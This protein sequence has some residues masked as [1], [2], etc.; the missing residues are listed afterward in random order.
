VFE[1]RVM[2]FNI[3]YGSDDDGENSWSKRRTLVFEVIRRHRLDV[4]GLQEALAW[5]LDEIGQALPQYAAVG[6]GRDDGKRAGEFAAILY[7]A[8]RFEVAEQGTF[9][10]SD[11]PEV[12]GSKSWGNALPRICT[13]ALLVDRKTCWGVYVYNLHLDHQSQPSRQRSAELL[14][15][16]ISGRSQFDPVVVVGDFNVG[17]G[18]SVMRYLTGQLPRVQADGAT[19]AASP[20]LVDTFRLLHPGA[21]RVATYHGFKGTTSGDRVDY[22]LAEPRARVQEAAILRDNDQGRYPSDHYP[23]FAALRLVP[24]SE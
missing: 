6:V 5:Q 23:V 2:S 8:D 13:W 18:D 4:I 12:P 17:R 24:G 1:L 16:R 22:V 10:L 15:E 19:G 11:T 9:W 14:A 21:D 7:L 20:N 3:R